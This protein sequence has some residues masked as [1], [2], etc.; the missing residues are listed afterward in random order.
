MNPDLNPDLRRNACP[1][2]AAPMETGDGLLARLPPGRPLSAAEL[3]AVAGAARRFG[4]GL[5]E[6]TARGSLQVR[7]LSPETAAPF[8]ESLAA[9]GITD[10]RPAIHVP[11][12]LGDEAVAGLAMALRD[13]IA[14]AGLGSHLAPKTA[15]V[16]DGPG[17]L[18]LDELDADLRLLVEGESVALAAG[19]SATTSRPLGKVPRDRAVAAAIA[20]LERL[21]RP[22]AGRGRDLD[23]PATIASIASLPS[24]PARRR[25]PAEPIGVHDAGADRVALGVALP[26]GQVEAA[27]VGEFADAA[28]GLG[29]ARFE[30]AAGRVLLAVGLDAAG[31]VALRRRAAGLGLI[32]DPADPRRAVAACPGAPACA[33]GRTPARTIAGPVAAAAGPILDGTV[34]LH[35]SGCPKGCAHPRAATL[36]LVGT[37]RGIAIAVNGRTADAAPL[38]PSATDFVDA[39]AAIS[40]VIA[41]CR[42]PGETAA[43]T[44]TR[45]GAAH[46]AA[47]LRPEPIDA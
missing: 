2:I 47:A 12:L 3:K 38:D 29:A 27:T 35:L 31:A 32:V 25:A 16:V 10:A 22:G 39:A 36:T 21:A 14:E 17:D 37:D 18:H 23:A 46:L 15:I 24:P 1:T 5:L 11:P 4:N 28:A 33:A 8:A 34:T 44:I 19:G 20:V 40:K 41:T 30:T 13:A 43:D 45:L 9:I 42:S 7:G 26:F 6:I